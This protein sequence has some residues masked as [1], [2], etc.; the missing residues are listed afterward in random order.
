MASD[1]TSSILHLKI[2]PTC[3]YDVSGLPHQHQCPECGF[4]YDE[5][6]YLLVANVRRPN[7]FQT[8]QERLWIAPA[9]LGFVVLTRKPIPGVAIPILWAL[10]II[11]VVSISVARRVTRKRQGG[12]SKLWI[13]REGIAV[14]N[15]VGKWKLIPWKKFERLRLWQIIG[16]I[17]TFTK[18]DLAGVTRPAQDQPGPPQLWRVWIQPGLFERVKFGGVEFE[19]HCTPADIELL[20]EDLRKRIETAKADSR[21]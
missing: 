6:M 1:V 20:V 14:Q 12:D 4:A 17:N 11:I 7:R 13:Q 9:L 10:V 2:C 19:I 3:G 16:G 21:R 8:W 18:H 15:A 5:G